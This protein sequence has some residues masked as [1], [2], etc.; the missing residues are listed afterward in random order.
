MKIVVDTNVLVSALIQPEGIPARILDLILSGQ[1]EIVLDNR[2]YA[3]YQDVLLRP[4]FGFAPELVDGLLEFLLQSG[5][6]VYSIK[7]SV[8]LPDVYDGKFLE[9]AIDGTADFLVTGNLK[10]FP[11]RQRRGVRVVSPRE[12]LNQWSEGE[13]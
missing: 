6:R 5:E 11:R 4:E 7:T 12:F 1:V 3:E 8:A 2:I 13:G 10:H 9:V